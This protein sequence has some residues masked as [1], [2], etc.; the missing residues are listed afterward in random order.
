MLFDY[1]KGTSYEMFWALLKKL[2]DW[3][4]G[5]LISCSNDLSK[6][7]NDLSKTLL[8]RNI[9]FLIEH[10]WLS[11]CMFSFFFFF[12][13]NTN[14]LFAEIINTYTF[15]QYFTSD[16]APDL[17]KKFLEIQATTECGFTLK[18]V[19][20]MIRTWSQ[21]HRTY[22]YSQDSSIIWPV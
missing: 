11:I 3:L 15:L 17:S 10:I 6:T 1:K 16:F 9:I 12:V 20:H 19:R 2:I 13:A 4:R 14:L 8:S 18:C 22:K 21:I 7:C 5:R